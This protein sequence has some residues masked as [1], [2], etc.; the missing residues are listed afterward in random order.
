MRGLKR[1]TG[2][3]NSVTL[4]HLKHG[5]RAVIT[6]IDMAE[7]AA[8]RLAARGIV[9]GTCVGIVCAGDPFLIGIDNDRWALNHSEAAAIHVDLVEQPRATLRALFRRL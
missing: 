9:P 6:Y 8:A 2:V 1:L 3:E 7:A 5:D 4:S